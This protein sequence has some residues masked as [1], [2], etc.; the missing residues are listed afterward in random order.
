[1]SKK[2]IFVLCGLLLV[3]SPVLAADLDQEAFKKAMDAYLANDPNV[4]KLGG[5]L[6]RY[7]QKKQ[8]QAMKQREED[9]QRQTEEQFK[10]PRKIDVADSPARGN[11]AAKVTIVEF[12][13]FQCPFCKRGAQT[14]D[15]VLKAYPNDVRLVFKQLP[16]PF[17][18]D[19]KPAARASLAA[20]RQGK[21]WEMHDKLFENQGSLKEE[22]FVQQAQA[23]GLNVEKF[24]ADYNDPKI[25]EMVERD[26][27][28][29][30][31]LGVGGTPGFFINGV[32]LSGA[33]PLPKF[34]E[35][36]DRWLNKLKAGV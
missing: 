28:L 23:L 16:L 33:Q 7:F 13:D 29:A 17:H 34:K 10:N 36:I 26:I 6:E 32:Q 31:E 25:A 24:K 4:E 27:K 12:S 18:Q 14:M 21:F 2:T 19:A 3:A 5:A 1:M 20:G 30:G 9:Q 35:I 8:Q 15:E 11:P 22:T